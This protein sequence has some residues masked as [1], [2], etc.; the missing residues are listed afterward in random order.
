MTQDILGYAVRQ[1]VSVLPDMRLYIQQCHIAITETGC[2]TGYFGKSRVA[3]CLSITCQGVIYSTMSVAVS[4]GYGTCFAVKTCDELYHF[5]FSIVHFGI[6]FGFQTIIWTFAR[7]PVSRCLTFPAIGVTWTNWTTN[8][9]WLL[10]VP[11][12]LKGPQLIANLGSVGR[13]VSP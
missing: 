5:I 10:P 12:S 4:C 11:V 6:P 1:P 8:K 2:N 13:F 3:A 7:H 9:D